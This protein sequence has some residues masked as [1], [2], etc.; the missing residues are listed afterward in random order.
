MVHGVVQWLS[1][2]KKMN[3]AGHCRQSFPKVLQFLILLLISRAVFLS[4]AA[5]ATHFSPRHVPVKSHSLSETSQYQYRRKKAKD[6]NAPNIEVST[7]NSI[8]AHDVIHY[9]YGTFP[10]PETPVF[11]FKCQES[12]VY[13]TKLPVRFWL[14]ICCLSECLNTVLIISVSYSV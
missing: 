7:T 5:H 3:S 4:A 10:S 6:A 12:N 9:K 2:R 11:D 8:T 1:G 14:V 13:A